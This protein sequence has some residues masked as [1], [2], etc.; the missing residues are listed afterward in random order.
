MQVLIIRGNSYSHWILES[1]RF[2]H[3]KISHD[4][5]IKISHNLSVKIYM[6]IFY[7]E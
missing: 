1:Y 2:I 4:S 5:S 3:V 7:S 6:T